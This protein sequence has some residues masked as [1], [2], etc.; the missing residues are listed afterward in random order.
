MRSGGSKRPEVPYVVSQQH[1]ALTSLVRNARF[2]YLRLILV[3]TPRGF[4]EDTRRGLSLAVLIRRG[5]VRRILREMFGKTPRIRDERERPTASF[6]G[7]FA[8]LLLI[9]QPIV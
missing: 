7:R 6:N 4:A 2:R 3:E 1:P 9:A 8:T 5:G